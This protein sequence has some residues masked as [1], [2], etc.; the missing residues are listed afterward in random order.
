MDAAEFAVV[1]AA[2]GSSDNLS[3]TFTAPT[4]TGFIV[5]GDN[6]SS[7]LAAGDSLQGLYA[8]MN[9]ADLGANGMSLTFDPEDVNDSGY[10]KALT[11]LTLKIVDF[12]RRCR[13]AED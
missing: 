12:G 9:T 2:T 5:T 11:P 1:N 10:S 7:P 13:A 3:G 6:L 8:S 4:G